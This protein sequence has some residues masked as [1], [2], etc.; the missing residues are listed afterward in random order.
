M[1][2]RKVGIGLIILGIFGI[3]F[4]LLRDFLSGGRAGIQSAQI[5]AIEVS[6]IILLAG[7]WALTREF[8]EIGNTGRQA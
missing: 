6:A 1:S 2:A 8:F 4:S 7:V 3:L 5:L